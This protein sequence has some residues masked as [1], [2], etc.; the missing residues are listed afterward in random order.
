MSSVF[1][2]NGGAAF[3]PVDKSR[4]LSPQFGKGK[5]AGSEW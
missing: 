5:L 1:P 2:P 4:G 3:I